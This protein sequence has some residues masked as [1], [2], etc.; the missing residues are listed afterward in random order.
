MR[1]ALQ[2]GLQWDTQ[3]TLGG[4]SRVVSQV[5]G[6]ALPVSYTEHPDE[7]RA[8]HRNCELRTLDTNRETARVRVRGSLKRRA[9]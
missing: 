6:S 4:A 5:Y 3:V 8:R 2:V 1:Q 7:L 9:G